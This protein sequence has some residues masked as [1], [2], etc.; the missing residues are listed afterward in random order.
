MVYLY[1]TSRFLHLCAPKERLMGHPLFELTIY[2]LRG[3][4][5]FLPWVVP[6]TETQQDN[7]S[8]W[9]PQLLLPLFSY[10]FLTSLLSSFSSNPFFFLS[11]SYLYLKISGRVMITLGH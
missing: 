6:R 7:S 11:F 4:L 1:W 2:L 8:I 5:D 3:L 10:Y 9:I